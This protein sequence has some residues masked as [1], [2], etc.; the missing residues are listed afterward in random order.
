MPQSYPNQNISHQRI[1][2][3][4]ED[5][6]SWILNCVEDNGDGRIGPKTSFYC[7]QDHLPKSDGNHKNTTD[8][9]GDNFFT[10]DNMNVVDKKADLLFYKLTD[11]T[12]C[13][14]KRTVFL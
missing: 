10:G 8:D 6:G 14:K 9:G 4:S 5:P 3:T 13:E 7:Q 12:C 11:Q 2:E 1:L